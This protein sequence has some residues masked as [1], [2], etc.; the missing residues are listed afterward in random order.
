[1]A[2]R[3][4][5]RAWRCCDD[6]VWVFEADCGHTQGIEFTLGC[7]SVCKRRW[8]SLHTVAAASNSYVAM[9]DDDMAQLQP[10][11]EGRAGRRLLEQLFDL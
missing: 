9:N 1:M 2:E 7:C 6:S 3:L 5:H 4:S 10:L 11:P 8:M